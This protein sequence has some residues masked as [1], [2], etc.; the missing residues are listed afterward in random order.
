LS[1]SVAGWLVPDWPVPAGVRALVT[2]RN[3]PG[4]SLPP[5]DA[6]NLGLH[7]GEDAAVVRANR[8]LL[9]RALMLSATPRWLHQVHGSRSLRLTEEL[10]TGE[11]EADAAFTT[12]PKV[13][14]AVLTADCLPI[15]VSAADGV[16]V[17]AIHAG[18]RG[19]AGG[20]LESCISR[21][22]TP[23]S[24]L[25]VWLG[26]AIAAVSYEVGEEVRM[27]FVAADAGS[28]AAFSASRPGHW[29]C[30]LS[31]LARRRLVALG[32]T[33]IYGG[34][35]DTYTDSRFYSYRRDRANSGR[36][37]SLIWRE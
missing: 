35:L 12:Q 18:W 34:T 4:N 25:L 14:L 28:A 10:T 24:Q 32:V 16:E 37:A 26:P 33:R 27:A 36:F 30:D 6:F 19:L 31:A 1:E 11:P 3:L 22:L 17:A 23:R 2:T 29:L 9:Q 15:L 13:V 5:Y 21:L 8:D 7:S 20:V